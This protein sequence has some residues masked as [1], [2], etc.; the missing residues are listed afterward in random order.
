V[1]CTGPLSAESIHFILLIFLFLICLRTADCSQKEK[2]NKFVN[3]FGACSR[4]FN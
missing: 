2:R 1:D 4:R 3:L